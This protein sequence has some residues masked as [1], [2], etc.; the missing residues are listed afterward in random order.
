MHEENTFSYKEDV[1]RVIADLM[2]KMDKIRESAPHFHLEIDK[3][4]YILPVLFNPDGTPKG[5]FIVPEGIQKKAFH[6]LKKS[7]KTSLGKVWYGND[8][9][10]QYLIKVAPDFLSEDELNELLQ[11]HCI[12]K[13]LGNVT[14]KLKQPEH[15]MEYVVGQGWQKSYGANLSRAQRKKI[16]EARELLQDCSLAIAEYRKIQAQ[17]PSA[18]HK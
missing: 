11:K 10:A 2:K 12:T 1:E 9:N 16:S 5:N 6:A 4:I 8:K 3:A 18:P 7:N 17:L 14:V 15:G 13:V